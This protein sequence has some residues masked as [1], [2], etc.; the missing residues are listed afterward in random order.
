MAEINDNSIKEVSYLSIGS[1]RSLVDKSTTDVKKIFNV[2][3]EENIKL[4]IIVSSLAYGK[5]NQTRQVKISISS[6][7]ADLND[8]NIIQVL[9]LSFG[10]FRSLVGKSTSDVK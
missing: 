7:M 9:Y 10:S 2:A 4:S 1:F 8:N 3:K 5:Q 6:A